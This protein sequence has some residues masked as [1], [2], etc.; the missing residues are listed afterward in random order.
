MENNRIRH[1]AG[2]PFKAAQMY[3]E[4]YHHNIWDCFA[5]SVISFQGC[6]F[7]LSFFCC[8]FREVFI[9]QSVG[10]LPEAP[11]YQVHLHLKYLIPIAFYTCECSW[12]SYTGTP[13]T[14]EGVTTNILAK[15]FQGCPKALKAAKVIAISIGANSS[16]AYQHFSC[17]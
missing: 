7:F 14:F 10:C 17:T 11:L 15:H 12:T 5:F 6:F 9:L 1:R 8:F 2:L 4:M 16:Q 13:S 3:Y